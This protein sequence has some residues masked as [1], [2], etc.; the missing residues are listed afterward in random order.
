VPEPSE[1]WTE[2]WAHI[3]LGMVFDA[4]GQRERAVNEYSRAKQT[5]DNTGGAQDAADR[6]LKKA[7]SDSP[8]NLDA[9][10]ATD[11]KGNE[12]RPADPP[13]DDRPKLKKPN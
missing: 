4:L 7:Y 8:Q 6:Y 10:G 3:Y 12:A 1:K 5:N 2:V 13:A 9:G 11:K